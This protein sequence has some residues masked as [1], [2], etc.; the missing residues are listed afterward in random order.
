VS[1][2]VKALG[3]ALRKGP[4]Q[5]ACCTRCEEPL[6]ST[7]AFSRYEFYCLCCGNLLGFVEPDG[8]DETPEIL[9]RYEGLKAEWDEHAAGIMPEGRFGLADCEKC[10]PGAYDHRD[11]AT[12]EEIAADVAAREWLKARVSS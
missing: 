9:A 12:G 4:P 7:M 8:K 5:M 2:A 11:H 10:S 6:I 3:L 1:E